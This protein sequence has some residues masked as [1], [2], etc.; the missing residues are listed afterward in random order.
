MR[1][2]SPHQPILRQTCV[3]CS[4]FTVVSQVSVELEKIG[5]SILKQWVQDEARQKQTMEELRA[6]FGFMLAL[7]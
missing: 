1:F 5:E 4:L 7:K 6:V 3:H 2:A